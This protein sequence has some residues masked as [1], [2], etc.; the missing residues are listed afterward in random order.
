MT[1][2]TDKASGSLSSYA[3]L[4]GR[5]PTRHPLPK[6]RQV[7]NDAFASLDAEFEALHQFSVAP[8]LRRNACSG[9]VC[10]RS[11]SHSAPSDS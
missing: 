10:F 5:V 1:R 6:I 2:S 9:P 11:C 7:E 3:D 8:R 4:E